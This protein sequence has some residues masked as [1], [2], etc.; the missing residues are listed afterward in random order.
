VSALAR[1]AAVDIP[2]ADDA[3]FVLPE[4]LT[5]GRTGPG[6]RFGE[7]VWDLRDFVP[8]S[9]DSFRLDFTTIADPVTRNTAK[10][11]LYS[12]L[13]RAVAITRT[14]GAGARPLKPTAAVAEL[15]LFHRLVHTLQEVGA[16]RLSDVTRGHLDAA[17]T[18]WQATSPEVTAAQVGVTKHLAAHSPF[19]TGD[20]LQVVPW[21]GRSALSLAGIQPSIENRTIRIPE[22]LMG[23]LLKAAVFYVQT[24]SGDLLAVRAEIAALHAARDRHP[25]RR[26]HAPERLRAFLARRHDERRGIPALPT[27]LARTCPPGVRILDEI[28]NQPNV[29][30]IALL[31]GGV[32]VGATQRLLPDLLRAGDAL[33]WED[34]GLDTPM[35]TWPDTERPWRTRLSPWTLRR[36]FGHLRTACWIVVAYLS[37][38]R[39]DEV[40]ELSCDCAFVE[41]ADDGRTC[42]KLRGR[43]YKGRQ[44]GGDDAE[45]VVLDVVHEA[46]DVLRQINDDPT[47]LFAYRRGDHATYQLMRDIPIRLVR[48]RDH[49][50]H[51]FSTAEALFIPDVP[52]TGAVEAAETRDGSQPAGLACSGTPWAFNTRQFR[53]TLAWHIAHQPFGVVAGT[54]QYQQAKAAVFEGYAGTSASGF[55]AEVA[56]EE[57]I[58]RLDYLEDLYHD[59]DSGGRATGGAAARINAEFATIRR[60]LAELPG[61]VAS[62]ARL[63]AM[64]QHLT[65]TL[66]P[67]VLNDCFYQP[68]NAACRTKA[69]QLRRPLPMLN[70][71]LSCSNARRSTVHMPRLTTALDQARQ[72]LA[73]VAK[74]GDAAPPLQL[75]AVT[76]H[77]D[78]LDQLVGDLLNDPK[79]T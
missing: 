59:W 43:V 46:V 35:S 8:R 37:G 1:T 53:R 21:P 52:V 56:A 68:A 57:V 40:R 39:D 54:R 15:R 77:A 16:A 5:S 61:T 79:E 44:V 58:A 22:Q 26:G 42:H 67:G 74:Y 18:R 66:H 14:G 45:W 70:A 51:L 36:E 25:P 48:F 65:K 12:R 62:P 63:R 13:R 2:A 10:E 69:K 72:A 28:V 11:Y 29:S 75:A 3:Y 31:A 23:P 33:G 73:L 78:Q 20:Q 4:H 64:L 34:G 76:Q 7:D 9:S 41:T 6:P 55:A 24:A 71:C 49:A 32:P 60:E 50:N 47:H 17:L 27:E 30:L 19:L 38:M